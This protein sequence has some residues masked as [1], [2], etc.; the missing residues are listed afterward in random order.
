MKAILAKKVGMTTIFQADGTSVPVTLLQAGPCTV[1]LVRPLGEKGTNIQIGF[2]EKKEKNMSKPQRG[3]L[4]GLPLFSKL[5][6]FRVDEKVEAK[7]GDVIDVNAFKAGDVVRVVGISKGKGYQ[8][9]VRRHNFGGAPRTH[10]HKHDLRAPG[11]IGSG[12]P[13]HVIKGMR[14]AGRMGNDRVTLKHV[15]VVDIVPAENILVVRGAVPGAKGA[16][17]SI[18]GE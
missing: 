15:T 13:Q 16:L 9:V 3:H 18:Q 4:K 2:G 7:R 12:W 1:T 14:M 11:S 6:E 17:V 10:G 5:M 8:G